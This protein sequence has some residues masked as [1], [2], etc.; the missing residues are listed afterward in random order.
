ME[1]ALRDGPERAHVN[2][3][4]VMESSCTRFLTATTEESGGSVFPKATQTERV[5]ECR[6]FSRYRAEER[7]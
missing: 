3:H 1:P 2:F 5:P 4:A 6:T 7:E